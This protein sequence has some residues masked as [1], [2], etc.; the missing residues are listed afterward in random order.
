MHTLRHSSATHLLEAGTDIRYI[1]ELVGYKST[2]TTQ[3]CTHVSK[4]NLGR[5]QSPLDSLPLDLRKH[6]GSET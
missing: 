2:K 1:Q 3:I 4:K 6:V 5:I